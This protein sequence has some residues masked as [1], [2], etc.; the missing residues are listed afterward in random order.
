MQAWTRF[1]NIQH[2][3]VPKL[4]NINNNDHLQIIVTGQANLGAGPDRVR[5]VKTVDLHPDGAWNL[6]LERQR[7][8]L[9]S[10][11]KWKTS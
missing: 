11:I 10:A 5:N 1:Q 3:K 7:M 6:Y 9:V 8:Q 4:L 2:V